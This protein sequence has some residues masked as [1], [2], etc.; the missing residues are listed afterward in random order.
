MEQIKIISGNNEDEI[1]Q[2]VS[3]DFA[4]DDEL[5]EYNVVLNQASRKV[6]LD[7]DIDPG[8]GFESGYE[9]TRL[10]AEIQQKNDFRFSIHHE[11]FV[12][13]MGKLLGMEDVLTGYKEFDEKLIVK[14]ND[15]EKVKSIFSDINA[16]N[17][18]QSLADFTLHITHHHIKDD[19]EKEP[20]L[21][22]EI[23]R[24]ITDAEELRKIYHAYFEILSLIDE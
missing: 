16:R 19:K 10:S 6:S 23:Q 2:Q 18:F 1:W 17:V 15:A 3:A 24:A 9:Y 21:E 22:L 8:G 13:K 4:A 12:D 14:T 20:F 11:G 7:I 5:L